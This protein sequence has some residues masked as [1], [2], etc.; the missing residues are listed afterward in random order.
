MNKGKN[1]IANL[2]VMIKVLLEQNL[3]HVQ[4]AKKLKFYS[5]FSSKMLLS[6]GG[7]AL[8][9][10]P[11]LY[12]YIYIRLFVAACGT[13]DGTVAIFDLDSCNCISSKIM[14]FKR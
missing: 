8:S 6:I 2:R 4:I 9:I 14:K 3:S 13:Y 11:P 10:W 5:L 12:I 1:I 7:G